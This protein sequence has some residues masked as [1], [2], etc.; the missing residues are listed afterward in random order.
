MIINE[1]RYNLR[2]NRRECCIPIQLHLAS[3]ADFLTASW[4]RADSSQSRQVAFTDLSDSGSNIDISTLVDHSDQ[5]L[6][7]SSVTFG[8]G[9]QNAVQ[10]QASQASGSNATLPG[11]H[12]I[13]SQSLSQLSTLTKIKKNLE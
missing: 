8:S 10:S 11:Q 9:V 13:H 12:H 1:G 6:S 7:S 3:D 2:S 4:K 5:N